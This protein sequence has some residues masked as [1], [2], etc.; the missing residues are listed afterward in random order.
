MRGV[1]AA[2]PQ[3]IRDIYNDGVHKTANATGKSVFLNSVASAKMSA[4]ERFL[5]EP[6]ITIHARDLFHAAIPKTYITELNKAPLSEEGHAIKKFLGLIS[7]EVVLNKNSDDIAKFQKLCMK[8]SATKG[9]PEKERKLQGDI[10]HLAKKYGKTASEN[11]INT[12]VSHCVGAWVQH[13]KDRGIDVTDKP[14]FNEQFDGIISVCKDTIQR[15]SG[16]DLPWERMTQEMEFLSADCTALSKTMVFHDVEDAL[17]PAVPDEP[18]EPAANPAGARPDDAGGKYL[19]LGG[20]DKGG[21][22]LHI[23]NSNRN[24]DVINTTTGLDGRHASE[25][26]TSSVIKS[27]SS[28]LSKEMRFELAKAYIDTLGG[29]RIINVV[30]KVQPYQPAAPGADLLSPPG[31]KQDEAGFV[32]AEP[33]VKQLNQTTENRF[34][35]YTATRDVHIIRAESDG[36][37]NARDR[38][39]Q[40]QTQKSPEK[41]VTTSQAMSTN[42]VG[43]LRSTERTVSR[44]T[45][46]QPVHTQHYAPLNLPV[47]TPDVLKS[48]AGTPLTS[49]LTEAETALKKPI[50]ND[51]GGLTSI[52]MDAAIVEGET[53][54]TTSQVQQLSEV[55]FPEQV[56][57]AGGDDAALLEDGDDHGRFDSL[58]MTEPS[59]LTDSSVSIRAHNASD[60]GEETVSFE[61][62][63]KHAAEARQARTAHAQPLEQLSNQSINNNQQ[64]LPVDSASGVSRYADSEFNGPAEGNDG[65]QPGADGDI[66]SDVH[67]VKAAVDSHDARNK[68]VESP[69][70]FE[71][72]KIALEEREKRIAQEQ[73]SEP[74]RS[75]SLRDSQLGLPQQG[76]VETNA[77]STAFRAANLAGV[78][79]H[80]QTEGNPGEKTSPDNRVYTTIR[81]HSRWDYNDRQVNHFAPMNQPVEVDVFKRRT[82]AVENKGGNPVTVKENGDE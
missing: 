44:F 57:P 36:V 3:T 70:L 8:L 15:L 81:T 50:Q 59:D 16:S 41:P 40:T 49:S 63:I 67:D 25:D 56:F 30:E 1:T 78:N 68:R 55:N 47:E 32:P 52:Y 22:T 14:I 31:N 29:N 65:L 38:G 53:T 26:P 79:N 62:M 74:P 35:N 37:D 11:I 33:S 76:S 6:H 51:A 27:L 23:D 58:S 19:L 54:L 45:R 24:G 4:E 18:Q 10:S 2:S 43:Q 75:P 71:E 64:G 39:T 80:R 77:K 82:D 12:Y 42:D 66:N 9:R 17:P 61:E 48:V 28:D 69:S 20:A 13:H 73:A 34:A 21:L 7:E 5:H 46:H 60:K 72:L